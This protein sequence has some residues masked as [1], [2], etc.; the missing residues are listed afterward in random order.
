[1]N[2]GKPPTFGRPIILTTAR[3]AALEPRAQ[4][5]GQ[6]IGG[7]RVTPASVVT[8]NIKPVGVRGGVAVQVGGAAG[9]SQSGGN[10]TA[11]IHTGK[12]G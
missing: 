7:R 5:P 4:S 1:M 10:V 3:A 2:E 11:N 9:V 8:E 12:R 6:N